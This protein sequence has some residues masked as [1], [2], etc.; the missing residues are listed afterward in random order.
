MKID[1]MKEEVTYDMENLRRKNE[2]ETQNTME[3][4]QQTTTSRRQNL[5]T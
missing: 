1:S 3:D 4:H 5:R 2:T